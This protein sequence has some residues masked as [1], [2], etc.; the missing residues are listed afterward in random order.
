MQQKPIEVFDD[1]KQNV[2]NARYET[3]PKTGKKMLVVSANSRQIV[4]PDGRK[5]VV[6][7]APSLD[8]INKFI[9]K[10]ENAQYTMLMVKYVT[11]VDMI[12]QI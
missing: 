2:F 9:E 7:E 4:H 6:I 12:D 10:E 3:D 11:C 5:D 1:T 8:L